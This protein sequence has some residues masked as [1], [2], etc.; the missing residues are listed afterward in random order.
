MN[1]RT[2][3][4][5]SLE[6]ALQEMESADTNRLR[7]AALELRMAIEAL[8][9]ERA[10]NYAKDATLK[11]LS[12]WQPKKLMRLLLE[13]D[14]YADKDA[15]ISI[16]MPDKEGQPPSAMHCLGKE[17]V[18]KLEEVEAFYDR[19]GSYLHTPTKAQVDAGEPATA[20]NILA[21]CR[22]LAAI[23][24]E[25][26]ESQII[27]S[28]FKPVSECKC[29]KCGSKVYGRLPPSRVESIATC[30][31][32]EAQYRLKSLPDEK[33]EWQ[34]MTK[35]LECSNKECLEILWVFQQDIKPGAEWICKKCGKQSRIVLGIMPAVGDG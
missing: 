32:C 3:A 21:K 35:P 18:L 12:K 34:P 19:L 23:L 15:V 31:Q 16:G 13:I 9:Y 4:K 28:D 24:Q 20:R 6:R 33:V 8:V 2:A 14:P 7:Y 30:L 10:K 1:Y 26:F 29:F 25:V 22:E 5:Q 17:R 27:N 11:Q